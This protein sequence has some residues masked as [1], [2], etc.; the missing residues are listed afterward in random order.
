MKKVHKAP[1]SQIS[2]LIVLPIPLVI[3]ISELELLLNAT[4]L[5]ES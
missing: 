1:A 3:L 4:L 2:S 5:A